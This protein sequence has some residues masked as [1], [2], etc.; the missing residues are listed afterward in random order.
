MAEL[1]RLEAVSA[2]Y[3]DS[4]VVEEVSF[5]MGDGECV[6]LLGRNGV[7]K[8]TLLTT[9]MGLTRFH[10][11]VIRWRGGD[12][13]RAPAYVRSRSEYPQA[14]RYNI[15]QHEPAR[16]IIQLGARSVPELMRRLG[17]RTPTKAYWSGRSSGYTLKVADVAVCILQHVGDKAVLEKLERRQ[18]WLDKVWR[19]AHDYK[20]R[21]K[22]W[23]EEEKTA[24]IDLFD[25]LGSSCVITLWASMGLKARLEAPAT[26][27]A[28][29]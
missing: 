14:Q 9:I 26:K 19:D 3:G 22:D 2:G 28:K 27:A 15:D 5:E 12:I 6:A 16:S 21:Q 18:A 24:Y 10:R 25:D 11:G 13:A 7:G 29:K 1:L 23:S 4:V 8:T 20:N 17:D